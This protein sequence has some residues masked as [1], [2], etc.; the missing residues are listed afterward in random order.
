MKFR[1]EIN[2]T[3]Q[4][5]LLDPQVPVLSIGSC[6]ADNIVS[7]MKS[8]LW[9]AVNP[10]GV[11]FNPASIAKIIELTILDNEKEGIEKFKNSIF[12]CDD[13]YL[14]WYLDSKTAAPDRELLVEKFINIR[15]R[16]REAIA[17]GNTLLITF[18]TSY[19]YE[20][21]GETVGNCHKQGAAQFTRKRLAVDTIVNDWNRLLGK[22]REIYPKLKCIFT[23]SPVRHLRDGAHDNTLS[24]SILHLAVEQL[25]L[26]NEGVGYFPAYEL[27][28][29][30]LRDYRFYSSDMAHPSDDAVNYI[31]EKFKEAY[32]D[33]DGIRRISEGENLCQRIRHRFLHPWSEQS[34]KFASDTEILLKKFKAS[35][36]HP[37]LEEELLTYKGE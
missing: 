3:P 19:I 9:P 26:Q 25:I 4:R 8:A 21:G 28:M 29:D 33:A 1:T 7:K 13:V 11:L 2:V 30:D 31:W 14:S 35:F 18:G 23:V 12:Q 17:E 32:L 15:V 6:F 37:I 27:L 24:K 16:A 22:L 20:R 10:F 34:I 36:P 5:G